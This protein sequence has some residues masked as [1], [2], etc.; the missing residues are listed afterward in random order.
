MSIKIKTPNEVLDFIFDFASTTN[1]G[2]T[3]DW[4]EAGETLLA[5]FS[6]V[7]DAGLTIDSSSLTNTNTSITVWIS[8]GT[9]GSRYNV[10]VLGTTSSARTFEYTGTIKVVGKRFANA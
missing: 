8:S 7:T 5:G 2:T 6:V 1:G 9:A 3:P 10:T 4:L